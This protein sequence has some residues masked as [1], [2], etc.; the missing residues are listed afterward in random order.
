MKKQNYILTKRIVGKENKE[1]G[2]VVK[3]TNAQAQHPFYRNRVRPQDVIKTAETEQD[4][5]GTNGKEE[6]TKEP[7]APQGAGGPWN[8]PTAES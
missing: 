6:G 5:S 4:D 7:T 8:Q 2:T 1:P 3:L